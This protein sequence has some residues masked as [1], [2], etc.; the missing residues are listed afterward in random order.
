MYPLREFTEAGGLMSCGS[1]LTDRSRQAGI[2]TGR[3][4]KGE[5]PAD[6]PVMRTTKFDLVINLRTAR[7]L[8]ITIPPSLHT[9]AEEVIE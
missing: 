8:G 6:L 7:M 1:N 2:Y 5:R 3:I 4:L 9:Q